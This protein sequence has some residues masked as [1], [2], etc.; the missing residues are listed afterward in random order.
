MVIHTHYYM[1]GMGLKSLLLMV[2]ALVQ[3]VGEIAH[4]LLADIE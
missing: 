4:A 2:I 3:C 1:E